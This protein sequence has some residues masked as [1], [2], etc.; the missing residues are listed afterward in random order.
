M[1]QLM[2][3]AAMAA[4]CAVAGEFCLCLLPAGGTRK[5]CRFVIGLILACMLL[6]MPLR[7]EEIHFPEIEEQKEQ[8]KSYEEIIWDVYHDRWENMNN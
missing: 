4:I 5:F 1:E 2:H 8:Q 3:G 6:A 7:L